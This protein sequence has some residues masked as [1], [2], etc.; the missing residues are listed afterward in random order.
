MIIIDHGDSY[1]SVYAHA[2][3]LFKAKDDR[4]EPKEVIATVG[5]TGSM[6]GPRLYFEVRYH[7]K[8]MDPLDWIKQG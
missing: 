6:F 7:G 8:P 5:D 4:V 3:E 1:Y 2:Q